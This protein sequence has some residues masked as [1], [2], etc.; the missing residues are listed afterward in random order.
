MYVFLALESTLFFDPLSAV[1]SWLIFSRCLSM[2][3]LSRKSVEISSQSLRRSRAVPA[4]GRVPLAVQ[5]L[6]LMLQLISCGVLVMVLQTSR[7]LQFNL[8]CWLLH[9]WFPSRNHWLRVVSA[10]RNP[11]LAP[12]LETKSLWLL[13]IMCLGTSM[14]SWMLWMLGR[15]RL[16]WLSLQFQRPMLEHK[17]WPSR[18]TDLLCCVQ[19]MSVS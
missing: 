10:L 6:L 5:C 8:C 13:L 16:Q 3:S 7:Q 11:S 14:N 17:A 19:R 9:D 2:E 15:V 1:C 4:N 18:V 12:W